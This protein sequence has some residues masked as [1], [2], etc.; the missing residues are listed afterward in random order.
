MK[1]RK[2]HLEKI[3]SELTD[4][5]QDEFTELVNVAVSQRFS[6]L[7]TE[8]KS[9]LQA[10]HFAKRYADAVELRDKLVIFCRSLIHVKDDLE[11]ASRR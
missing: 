4:L 10:R 6:T 8:C 11:L 9:A 7:S 1:T 3:L 5:E 2:Q